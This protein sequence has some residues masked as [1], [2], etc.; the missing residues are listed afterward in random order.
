MH[1]SELLTDCAFGNYLRP[2]Y[3]WKWGSCGGTACLAIY[4]LG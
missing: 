3:G 2:L 1:L 4:D